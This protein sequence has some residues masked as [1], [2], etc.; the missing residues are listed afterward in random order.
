[1]NQLNIDMQTYLEVD[2]KIK[3]LTEQ[4]NEI[5]Q[6]I[7]PL[8]EDEEYEGLKLTKKRVIS[9]NDDSFL[10]W[11]QKDFPHY[12]DKV[13]RS[14]LDYEKFESYVA[15]GEIT[16]EELPESV[17]KVRVDNVITRGKKSES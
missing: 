4:K 14:V 3:E 15:S 13:T 17:Y 16:Y 6:R 12:V 2:S 7:I 9:W 10:K 11:V 5:R 1:M 8:L